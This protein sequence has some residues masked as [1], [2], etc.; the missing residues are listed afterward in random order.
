MLLLTLT[1]TRCRCHVVTMLL[2]ASDAER[3]KIFRAA[4]RHAPATRDVE[5]YFSGAITPPPLIRHAD[6]YA[7]EQSTMSATARPKQPSAIRMS[8]PPSLLRHAERLS[9]TA[10]ARAC[11][12]PRRHSI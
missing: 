7:R 2:L 10:T 9:G 3:H 5:R 6:V 8:A 12:L 11:R 1:M 4:A